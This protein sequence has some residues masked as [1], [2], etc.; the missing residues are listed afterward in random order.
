[1]NSSRR[2]LPVF[3]ALLL[4]L[5]ATVVLH[6]PAARANHNPNPVQNLRATERALTSITVSWDA[7]ASTTNVNFYL[8]QWKTTTATNY[9]SVSRNVTHGTSREIPNL[10]QGTAYDVRVRACQDSTT[11]HCSSA[12][13][14]STGTPLP[15]PSSF[16]ARPVGDG[17]VNLRYGYGN[18]QEVVG[19][20]YEYK[21]TADAWTDASKVTGVDVSDR[22]MINVNVT[23][24]DVGASYD[25]RV[26]VVG[27]GGAGIWSPVRT[28]YGK[29]NIPQNFGA[30]ASTSALSVNLHWDFPSHTGGGDLT[31][32]TINW[33][34]HH[35]TGNWVD[36]PSTGSMEVDPTATSVDITAADGLAPNTNYNFRIS[37]KNE[38]RRSYWTP[39]DGSVAAA[40]ISSAASISA[41]T[42][43]TLKEGNLDGAE[44][45]VDLAGVTYAAV[46]DTSQFSITPAVS[47]LSVFGARRTDSDTIVLTLAY[48]YTDAA[49]TSDTD[50]A[51]VV[52]A[53]AHSGSAD[54]TTDTVSVGHFMNATVRTQ[55]TVSVNE[56]DAASFEVTLDEQVPGS[57]DLTWTAFKSDGAVGG[58]DFVDQSGV[59]L[60]IPAGVTSVTITTDAT[61]DDVLD[62]ENEQFEILIVISLP[63]ELQ[64][65]VFLD[66]TAT[67]S[68]V[69]INDNDDPPVLTVNSPSVVEGDTAHR[70]LPFTVTLTPASGKQVTVRYLTVASPSTA[71]VGEDYDAAS[72]TLTFA[73]GETSKTVNVTV[74]GFFVAEPAETVFFELSQPT[75]AT[76]TGG[77]TDPL[78]ATGTII[79]ND[80]APTTISLSLDPNSVAEEASGAQSIIV[81]AAFPD[82]SDT[83]PTDTQVTV[84][85]GAPGDSATEGADYQNVLDFLVTISAG[86]TSRTGTLFIT[87]IDDSD[88]EGSEE[89]TVSGTAQGFTVMPATL[90]LTED[91]IPPTTSALALS[92]TTVAEN[93][94]R[95]TLTVTLSGRATIEETTV[96]VAAQ[97]GVFTVDQASK[98]IAAGATSA[99]FTLT[100]VPNDVDAAD[101]TAS[102]SVTLTGGTGDNVVQPDPAALTFTITDDDPTPR[103]TLSVLPNPVDEIDGGA[104]V[105]VTASLDRPSGQ[106][107]TLTVSAAPAT[108]PNPAETA[109]FTL[110]SGV[111]LTIAAGQTA[112]TGTV[113]ITAN[114]DADSADERVTVSATA[115]NSHGV[116]APAAVT[117]TIR[118][119]DVPGARVT[120]D[121]PVTVAEGGTATYTLVLNVQPSGDVT[122]RVTPGRS[123]GVT[124]DTDSGTPG[125]QDTVTF[126]STTWNTAQTVTVTGAQD[127]DAVDDR[128]SIGH[129][130]VRASTSSEYDNIGIDAVNV[131]VTDDDAAGFTI[132]TDPDTPG[133]QRGPVAVVEGGTGEY[134]VV[135]DAAPGAGS[136]RISVTSSD[137]GAARAS[138]SSLTFTR[139]NWDDP[140]TVRV[141]G[142]QDA[143]SS[144]ETVTITHAVV[145]ASSADE[146]DVLADQ[147]VTVNVGDDET[148]NYDSDGDGLIEVH[149]LAQLNAVRW[150][151]DGNGTPSAGDEANYAAAFENPRDGAVCPS[152]TTCTGYELMADLDFD[153]NGD[154]EITAADSTYWNGGSGWE[155]IG[156]NGTQAVYD[157]T[158]D[159]NGRTIAN[160]FIDRGSTNKQGLF[161]HLDDGR[162]VRDLGLVNANVTGGQET[163]ALVGYNQGTVTRSYVT[164]RVT[165]TRSV[166]GLVGY[167]DAAGASVFDSYAAVT[168][169]GGRETGGLVG[170]NNG[171]VT[172]SYAVGRV[173]TSSDVSINGN[174]TNVGGLVGRMDGS[175]A[176]VRN[177]YSG[178]V[179]E[180]SVN[181]GS[182]A[183]LVGWL[184]GGTVEN[185]FYDTDATPDTDAGTAGAQTVA[186]R[187]EAAG[188]VTNVSGRSREEL[189]TPTGASGIYSAWDATIWDFGTATQ[190]PAL[191]GD[192]TW[193]E[194]GYQVREVPDITRAVPAVDLTSVALEWTT[195]TNAWTSQ[196]PRPSFSYVVYRDD[197]RIAPDEGRTLTPAS[198]TDRTPTAGSDHRYFVAVEINGVELRRGAERVVNVSRDTD[199]DGLIE[200]TTAQQLNAMRYD[201]DGDGSVDDT[202]NA[203]GFRPLAPVGGSACPSGTDCTGYEL[204]NNISLFGSWTP[205]GGVTEPYVDDVPAYDAV[206]EGNGHRI[207]GL[208]VSLGAKE[209]IGLFGAVA[210]GGVIR[211]VGLVGVNVVGNAYVGALVGDNA[212]MVTASYVT[213]R[214]SG[215][216]GDKSAF[217]GGLVGNNA[218]T[219][220]KSYSAAVVSGMS[221]SG[222]IGGLVGRN[223][224]TVENSYASGQVISRTA[225]GGLVGENVSPNGTIRNSYSVAAVSGETHTGGLI[226]V[227]QAT[228][229]RSYF[230]TETSGQ[231][232]AAGIHDEPDGAARTTAQ[233]QNPTGN[234]GIYRGWDR[235]IWDFGRYNEYPRLIGD[236]FGAQHTTPT[237]ITIITPP[238]TGDGPVGGGGGP[239]GPAEPATGRF[240]DVD[241]GSVHAPAIAAIAA[242]G[243]TRGCDAAGPRF[244]PDQPVT[245]AQMASFLARALNLRAAVTDYFTDDDSSSHE[246][247]INALR[248]AGITRGCDPDGRRFCPDQPVT[249]AQMASFLVRALDLP[250]TA[251]DY[252][253]DDDGSSHEANINALR[254]VGIT[255]GCDAAGS[256]FCPDDAVTRAQ[257]ATFLARALNLT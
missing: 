69:T 84:S 107:T 173:R 124:V 247:N 255:R 191:R 105:T 42:P 257:M 88:Q 214:V 20:R 27:H 170:Q 96:E 55:A 256:R 4:G 234:W 161:G 244:C 209:R 29:P 204:S 226:G 93:G 117:L 32:Y 37:A 212:G 71:T 39:G 6:A 205:I 187:N 114:A 26:H 76:F 47:G 46:F 89:I 220:S 63:P 155:P 203:N 246:A 141:T 143:D 81:T 108:G 104:T 122:I 90:T 168:V 79:D 95:T 23:G 159:G 158:F 239:T 98:T 97:A 110:S 160:L 52:A 240:E 134:T 120:A 152:G 64:G 123:S 131:A 2:S 86:T 5:L 179:V 28:I 208:R 35:A 100:A 186:V 236:H 254:A 13:S 56:G 181:P 54:L 248:A 183:G 129:A 215:G 139:S 182:T 135:L 133:A 45:T 83:L 113:E 125:D 147:T 118:D 91:D 87:P 7:P 189:Q 185:S 17:R 251:T 216:S 111:E 99:T 207:T 49:M 10:T 38:H 116:T 140:Q 72:G 34:P 196:R 11:A 198:H 61:I 210:S 238:I 153:E 184:G 18:E 231:T 242:A 40:T 245:R 178:V 250:A 138:R 25:F 230:D 174:G 235:T 44:L 16:L 237:P 150:D 180:N 193:Q 9:M 177:S 15:A 137:T 151:R 78:Q 115:T 31:G 167:N 164:G 59:T 200:I 172:D 142:Q 130:I 228:V 229:I 176:S 36:Q 192:A 199:G 12:I 154:G 128:G 21:K 162:V 166:G 51:V 149:N 225:G 80:V 175:S 194:F 112:S 62:E 1:M 233:L 119:D 77:N 19:W 253:T 8:I 221:L 103:A 190:Y 157:A 94:G 223:A 92:Q 75:N 232:D 60:T 227:S 82:G 67:R 65:K 252:F 74:R 144:S 53:A 121:D 213:G 50:I 197:A 132:D 171:P 222:R 163:G 106:A 57:F 211:Q 85:A 58:V 145:D 217:I 24:L 126:T 68:R 165:G 206:F 243:I 30:T 219:V 156:G 224:R 195:V 146:F 201:L 127:D 202:S 41:T 241:A 109:D 218:G 33:R 249:R 66:G 169:T 188:T 102:V 22:E 70:N 43:E 148:I 136:V 73:P 48:D 14:L 101:A 3:A